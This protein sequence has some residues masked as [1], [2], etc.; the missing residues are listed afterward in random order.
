VFHLAAYAAEGLSHFIKRFNYSN[1]LIGSV[2]LINA[3]VNHDVKCFVFT[4]SIAV[5]GEAQLPMDEGTRPMP[6][7]SYGIAKYAVEMELENSHRMF[8]LDY[9]IFRPHNVYGEYQNIGDTYR[10]VIGIFMNQIMLNKPLTVF[11]DGEQTRAFSYI[12]DV[13]PIIAESATTPEAYNQVFNVGA[14][15]PETVN[16][17]AETVARAM[18]VEPRVVHL[19]ARNEVVHAYSTHEKARTVFGDRE[20]V[21]L[22]E[23]VERMAQWA[24]QVGPRKSTVF[25]NI[26]ITKNLPPSWAALVEQPE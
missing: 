12:G 9:V 3:S 19:D 6:E 24:K 26:E 11:G 22:D 25:K 8:G 1:N 10:N 16:H 17:L 20:T 13:A 15:R 23:G 2:N 5:Y 14:D 18:G 7:D 4:S 21:P